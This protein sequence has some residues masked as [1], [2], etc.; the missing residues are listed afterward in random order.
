MTLLRFLVLAFVLG[1]L[2]GKWA[3]KPGEGRGE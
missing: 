3:G 1:L 2:C